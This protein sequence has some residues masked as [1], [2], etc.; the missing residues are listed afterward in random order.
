MVYSAC[1]DTDNPYATS[2]RDKRRKE[3]AAAKKVERE[4]RK[5]QQQERDEAERQD[6]GLRLRTNDADDRARLGVDIEDAKIIANATGTL[7]RTNSSRQTVYSIKDPRRLSMVKGY[8]NP[9]GRSPSTEMVQKR[10]AAHNEA[11]LRELAAA[12]DVFIRYRNRADM[13]LA[14]LQQSARRLYPVKVAA[15]SQVLSPTN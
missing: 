8:R 9:Y 10:I 1:T 14:E 12:P 7:L 11:Y 15:E 2:G 5:Q 4:L 13:E 6:L 3:R